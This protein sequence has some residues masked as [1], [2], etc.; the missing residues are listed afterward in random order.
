MILE[1]LQEIHNLDMV[2]YN[3]PR[4]MKELEFTTSLDAWPTVNQYLFFVNRN[5]PWNQ[6]TLGQINIMEAYGAI[7]DAAVYTWII[8]KSAMQERIGMPL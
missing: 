3:D 8:R 4:V 1:V 5:G 6:F 2:E 7:Y